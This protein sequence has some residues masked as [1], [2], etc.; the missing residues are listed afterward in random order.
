MKVTHF[1]DEYIHTPDLSSRV[2]LYFC[3]FAALQLF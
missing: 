2:N 1:L 3:L